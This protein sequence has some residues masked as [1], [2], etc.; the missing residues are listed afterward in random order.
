[1]LSRAKARLGSQLANRYRCTE[2]YSVVRMFRTRERI[3][4]HVEAYRAGYSRFT[5]VVHVREKRTKRTDECDRG[6]DVTDSKLRQP[7]FFRSK[8]DG[9]HCDW[10]LSDLFLGTDVSFSLPFLFCHTMRRSTLMRRTNATDWV[11]ATL[12]DDWRL[13]SHYSLPSDVSHEF[14]ESLSVAYRLPLI[15][16]SQNG[17]PIQR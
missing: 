2:F 10:L 14:D 5:T 6:D 7:L 9:A 1:M 12:A 16:F 15:L 4:L 17:F 11:T 8:Y 3:D 13:Y